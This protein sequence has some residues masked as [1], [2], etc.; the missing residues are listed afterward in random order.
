[1]EFIPCMNMT[2]SDKWTNAL[3]FVLSEGTSWR[4]SG[5]HF[6]GWNP[7]CYFML[8]T[9]A[10]NSETYIKWPLN[11]VVSQ[12]NRKWSLTTG[13]IPQMWLLMAGP[14]CWYLSPM[15]DTVFVTHA[16]YSVV[17]QGSWSL[18]TG[19]IPQVWLMMAGA[20][21]VGSWHSCQIQWNL[22]KATHDSCGLSMQVVFDNKE[23]TSNVT[24]A[25]QRPV[26][27][28]HLYLSHMIE[29]VKSV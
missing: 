19:R 9:H 28:F 24:S 3:D 8:I 1:M 22:Y 23:N 21:C 10:R 15:L 2:L 16:R 26:L 7:L 13:R 20:P 29:A 6:D 5:V 27:V 14:L 11:Y 4:A 18:V 17:S 25:G 12:G